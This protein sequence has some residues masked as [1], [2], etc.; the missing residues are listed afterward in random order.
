MNLIGGAYVFPW[1]SYAEGL[2]PFPFLGRWSETGS[3]WLEAGCEA[4]EYCGETGED[5]EAGGCHL[6]ASRKALLRWQYLADYQ[7]SHQNAGELH[8]E[9]RVFTPRQARNGLRFTPA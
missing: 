9:K 6:L 2:I 5:R 4:E 1:G 7:T 8:A 3:S